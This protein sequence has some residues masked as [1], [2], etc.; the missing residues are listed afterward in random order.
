MSESSKKDEVARRHW[1]W[2]NWF[3]LAFAG[4]V[5]E[6]SRCMLVGEIS[7]LPHNEGYYYMAPGPIVF[8]LAY[9]I[10]R[11]EWARRNGVNDRKVKVL[12]RAWDN[13][14]DWVSILAC[15]GGAVF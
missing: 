3:L 6:A 5:C 14:I 1:F 15:A 8:W 4:T 7:H 12:T 9:F 2:N 11:K 13:R 10:Y